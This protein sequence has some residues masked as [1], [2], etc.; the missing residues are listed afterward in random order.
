MKSYKGGKM[1]Q[2]VYSTPKNVTYIS[3]PPAVSTRLLQIFKNHHIRG[4]ESYPCNLVSYFTVH[5]PEQ[6]SIQFSISTILS[7]LIKW[8][9]NFPNLA[10]SLGF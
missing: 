3:V 1:K 7:Y 5:L 4:Q 9:S 6:E 8:R 10:S 2:K